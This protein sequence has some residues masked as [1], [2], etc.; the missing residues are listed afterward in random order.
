M[1]QEC[2]NRNNFV[3]N[4]ESGSRCDNVR[5][6]HQNVHPRNWKEDATM[7]T[8]TIYTVADPRVCVCE[9]GAGSSKLGAETLLR[10]TPKYYYTVESYIVKKLQY[11]I[12]LE[13]YWTSYDYY[14]A[15]GRDC[16][17]YN[18]REEAEKAIHLTA[19]CWG[20]EE[21]HCK[22]IE[23]FYDEIIVKHHRYKKG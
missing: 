21:Q 13:S 15:G 5:S 4:V 1:L 23:I 16:H 2:Y 8:T 10:E 3:T 19:T 7:N 22:V 17:A 6:G 14:K 18:S 9:L 11:F 12:Q 20:W